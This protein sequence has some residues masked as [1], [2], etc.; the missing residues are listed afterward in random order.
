MTDLIAPNDFF[1]ASQPQ[2][3]A[4]APAPG[5]IHPDEFFA[6]PAPPQVSAAL[7]EN[8]S[9]STEQDLGS[10]SPYFNAFHGFTEQAQR[11]ASLGLSD[12]MAAAVPA[13]NAAVKRGFNYVTGGE[14]P[15]DAPSISDIYHTGLERQR[16]IGNTYAENHPVASKVASTIGT[17][18]AVGP[19]AAAAPVTLGGKIL[20]GVTG[21]AEIGGL[22]GFGNSNDESAGKTALDT[23]QGATLGAAVG[24]GAAVLADKVVQPVMDFVARKFGSGAVEDQ[25]IRH[26]AG[27]MRQ[28]ATAGGPTAQD[29][30]DILNAAPAKP[31]TIADVAGE[32]VRAG[33]GSLARQP[34]PARQ[35]IAGFLNERDAGAGSRLAGDVD[36]GISS[37]GTA[38]DTTQALMDA[39]S[40]AAAPNY[41]AAFKDQQVWSPRLGEFLDDPVTKQGLKAG[42]ELERIDAVTHG[43]KFDPTQLGVDLDADGNVAFKTVPNMRVLD[44]G[45]RGLD[46]MIAGERNA[47]TGRL[48][49]RGVALDQFRRA[50]VGQ[51]DSLDTTGNYAAARASWAGPSA[52]MDAV[53]QG[54]TLLTKNPQEIASE[55]SKLSPGDQEFYKLG[56]ADSLKEKIAKTGM[57]GDEAK[58]II[59]NQWTQ[60]QLRPLFADQP[61]F[62]RFINSVTTENRMFNT[63]QAVLGNSA[64]AG[65]MAEDAAPESGAMGHLVRAGTAAMEGAPVAATMSGI[66]GLASLLGSKGGNP[67]VNAQLGRTLFNPNIDANRLALA[68][69]LAA[70]SAPSLSPAI[71]AP[72]ASLG[73][74][75]APALLR[76]YQGKQP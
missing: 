18:A 43:R 37:G 19:S 58:R 31:Q 64:T 41:D 17:L 76:G 22:S 56:A 72:L 12:K 59:G 38:H 20:Q 40:A 75:G 62:D 46:A 26:I 25:A 21:G 6:A 66:R 1:G 60:M 13:L 7:P 69:I 74:Q 5:L 34:G 52:S 49:Q 28:D 9:P 42:M 45:K 53:R 48:S 36:A 30:L 71:G 55:F 39:R 61:S 32:N 54:Q 51:L 33:A 35:Q 16:Q 47:V 63:R 65:R 29:M 67:E 27:R 8:S 14:T 24:G 2:A 44:A 68:R 23:A 3:P 10:L 11:A 73:A 57:G 50:Y 70:Q 4:Q 15:A